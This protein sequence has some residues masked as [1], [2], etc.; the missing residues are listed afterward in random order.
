MEGVSFIS[1]NSGAIRYSNKVKG[2]FTISRDN[3][4]SQLYLQMNNPK[5]EDM[6]VYYCATDIRSKNVAKPCVLTSTAKGGQSQIQL[7]EYGGDVRKPGESLRLSC[8]AS[9]FTFSS[10][11]MGWVRQA[12]GK[13]LELVAYMNTSPSTYYS[14]K[15]KG[16]TMIF[17]KCTQERCSQ[18]CVGQGLFYP[19][20]YL[21]PPT[22]SLCISLNLVLL[23][24]IHWSEGVKMILLFNLLSLLEVMRGIQSEIQLVESG[25]DKRRPGESLHLSC[26]VSGFDISGYSMQWVRQ[27][28]GKGLEWVAEISYNSGSFNYADRVKGHFTTSRTM[29][30]ISYTCK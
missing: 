25:G 24:P 4:K 21:H 30:K 7:V 26:Q 17:T 5:Q 13:G 2:C 6:T 15:V 28:P 9:G 10:Y 12:P 16:T 11:H 23:I 3:V 27:A 1:Y 20:R 19:N 8:Q 14:D 29:P 22:Q 18:K